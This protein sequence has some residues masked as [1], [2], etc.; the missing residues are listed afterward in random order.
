[1]TSPIAGKTMYER[2]RITSE[3]SITTC[4]SVGSVPPSCVY[5]FWKIGTMKSSI[6][7]RTTKE[8]DRTSVG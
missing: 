2:L 1:M 8:K 6:A 7:V 3:T 5:S 4:V